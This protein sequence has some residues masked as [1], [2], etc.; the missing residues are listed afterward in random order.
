METV[1]SSGGVVARYTQGQDID[2]PL[3]VQ[4]SGVTDYYEADGL[5]SITSLSSSAGA[6][7]DTYTY[8]SFGNTTNSSGSVTNFFRYTAREFDT[9]TGLYFL[10]ARYLDPSAGRF[11][12]EDPIR[13]SGGVNF[14]RYVRNNP[15]NLIDPPGLGPTGAGVGGVIGGILGGIIGVGAGAGGGTL[16]APGVGT[17]GGGIEGGV[18]GAAAGAAVG[19]AIGAAIGNAIE[20]LLKR[21]PTPSCNNG[22]VHCW[23]SGEFKDPS[24]DPKFKMCSYS[25]SDGTARVWVI[26]IGLPCP[27]TPD[28]LPQ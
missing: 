8:D 20:N 15:I 17:I 11:L 18:E 9:E 7:A 27:A 26:H 6:L 19:G 13:Y 2:E 14:Y 21:N 23:L 22:Q 3:A 25:C 24:L 1:N 5:G 12:S 16:V 28:R 10:R 4:R